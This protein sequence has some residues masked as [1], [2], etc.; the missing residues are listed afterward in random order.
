MRL[1]K[2]RTKETLHPPSENVPYEMSTI[3]NDRML[4]KCKII[5]FMANMKAIVVVRLS[6]FK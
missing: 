2:L 6:T 3:E 1:E 5:I 4:K